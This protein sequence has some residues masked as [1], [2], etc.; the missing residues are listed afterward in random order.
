MNIGLIYFE[1]E[2]VEKNEAV[3]ADWFTKA[4]L[5]GDPGSAYMLGLMYRDGRGV[6]QSNAEAIKWWRKA[7][8]KGDTWAMERLK[9][10]GENW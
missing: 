3:A 10:M 5:N 8:Q 7:A 9:E 2:G 4:A 6:E 1:G